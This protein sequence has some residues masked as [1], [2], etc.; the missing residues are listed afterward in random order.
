MTNNDDKQ[1]KLDLG[2]V[3]YISKPEKATTRLL[4][5]YIDEYGELK[6]TSDDFFTIL[7]ESGFEDIPYSGSYEGDDFLIVESWNQLANLEAALNGWKGGRVKYLFSGDKEKLQEQANKSLDKDN[8]YSN[9]LSYIN[10]L[11]NLEAN[12]DLETPIAELGDFF[13]DNWG[14]DDEYSLCACGNCNS[15]VRISADSY[16]WMPPL[17]LGEGYISDDCV[18][19]GEYDDEILEHYANKCMS[20]PDVRSPEDLGLEK[21]N[22]DSFENGLYGGQRDTP[23]PIIEALSNKGIDVWFKVYKGQ[24]DISFDVYVKSN[25]VRQA[26]DILNN[27][28]TKLGYDPAIQVQRALKSISCVSSNTDGIVVNKVDT[29]TGTVNTKVISKQDFIDGKI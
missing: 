17:D 28:N 1:E 12:R 9:T 20:I 24:F 18:T 26:I 11:D 10:W 21:I 16:N 8:V 13:S 15:V 19:S 5:N 7:K 27:T 4:D 29:S 2:I 23:E 6:A 22:D 25:D 14:F 3:E